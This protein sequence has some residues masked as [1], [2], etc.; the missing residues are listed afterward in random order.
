MSLIASDITRV[1]VGLGATGLSV[2]RHFAA[3]GLPF[4]VADSRANP[5]GLETFKQEFPQVSLQL[6]DFDDNQFVSA[7]ELYVNPGIPLSDPAIAAAKRAGVRISGDIDCFAAEARAPIVAITGSNGK[8]TV[9]TLVGEMARAAGVRVA[10]GGNLGVPALELLD[11]QCELYVLELSSFQLERCHNLGAEVATVLN[12]SADHLDHHG[13][14]LNYHQAKHRI[15]QGC[16]KAV[17]NADDRLS[18][19]LVPDEVE[20]WYFGLGQSDFRRF[21]LMASG[22]SESIALARQPLVGVD[23]LRIVGRH[24]VSN[25][26]AALALGAAAGLPMAVMLSALRT[27][28]G[29]AHRCEFVAEIGGVTYYND[30]KATNVGAAVAAIKGLQ[31]AGKILLVAGGLAKGGDFAPLAQALS[32]N[33]RAVIVMGRDA[34]LL[35]SAMAG[36]VTTVRVDT[37]EQAVAEAAALAQPGDRVLLAP[38]CASFD[39]F[40]GYAHRG[41][42]FT[43]AVRAMEAGQ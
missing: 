29:L 8:S 31:S 2:A 3:R 26:M 39:M 40:K 10:V 36:Q 9:T 11:D 23:E 32:H 37:M 24:N 42:C 17:I 15:F 27:F 20:Q 41:E 1:I 19:P 12:V 18:A 6:G 16:R 34:A 33:A 43:K 5:P 22:Q 7:G 14:M 30:S 35:E 25:A 13:S 28:N 38:A 4:A 21:G